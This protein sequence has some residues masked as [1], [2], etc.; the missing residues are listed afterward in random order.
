M[1]RYD[2]G[3]D[4]YTADDVLEELKEIVDEEPYDSELTDKLNKAINNFILAREECNRY[5]GHCDDGSEEFL[6]E[7]ALIVGY[8]D[9]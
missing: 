8:E 5:H 4:I 2:Y 1:F 7:V 9:C 6:N 3:N